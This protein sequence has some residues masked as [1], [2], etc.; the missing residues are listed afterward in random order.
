LSLYCKLNLMARICVSSRHLTKFAPGVLRLASLLY[1]L[2]ICCRLP[3]VLAQA[4]ANVDA[5]TILK[6]NLEWY[7]SLRRY[8]YACR[9]TV[10]HPGKRISKGDHLYSALDCIRRKDGGRYEFRG[11]LFRTN[12]A[13]GNDWQVVIEPDR[14]LRCQVPSGHPHNNGI[15]TRK[16]NNQLFV[17][18]AN[19][20]LGGCLDG[21]L[22]NMGNRHLSRV[23][24]DS[25]NATLGSDE[26]IDGVPSYVVQGATTH[27]KI[28]VR[29]AKDSYALVAFTVNK[30][31]DDQ[32]WGDD[33][34]SQPLKLL[35]NGQATL[36]GWS[37]SLSNV[38]LTNINGVVL[39]TEGDI[40][41]ETRYSQGEPF[42]EVSHSRRSDIKINP[43]FG[44]DA[45]QIGF[46][47]GANI[48]DWD[49]LDSGVQLTWHN[50]QLALAD[51]T[52][53]T[54][55]PLAPQ[56]KARGFWLVVIAANVV[57]AV[58]ISVIW[59]RRR[60]AA[61]RGGQPTS[62]KARGG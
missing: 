58:L 62:D 51:A 36:Q 17:F 35:K 34:D 8:Q 61:T 30:G 33:E 25:G 46:S 47:E 59:L 13:G 41:D 24:L 28:A 1:F 9:V 15:I 20:V 29:I 57:L 32:H 27:G 22:I 23:L 2:A 42:V 7:E 39:A 44:P 60:T 14:V 26:T 48:T 45:F 43:D 55:V 54:E 5:A 6:R 11:Q 50:S 38:R 19:P 52:F 18:N 37:A 31:P 21:E 40:R 16:V 53:P 4:P 10:E 3:P 12:E 56:T 49:H